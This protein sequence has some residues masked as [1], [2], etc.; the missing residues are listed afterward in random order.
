LKW[1]G[2]APFWDLLPLEDEPIGFTE[3]FARQYRHTLSD[4]PA[5]HIVTEPHSRHM[6][7]LSAEAAP[8]RGKCG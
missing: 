1:S 6:A 3:K 5:R 2:F 7:G 4:I 8:S